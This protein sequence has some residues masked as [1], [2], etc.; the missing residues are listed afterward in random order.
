VFGSLGKGGVRVPRQKHLANEPML[1]HDPVQFRESCRQSGVAMRRMIL[2][3]FGGLLA[4]VSLISPTHA[5][6]PVIEPESQ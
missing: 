6:K 4:A 3:V 1:H 2:S 5:V